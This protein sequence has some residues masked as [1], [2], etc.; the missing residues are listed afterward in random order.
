MFYVELLQRRSSLFAGQRW[1]DFENQRCSTALMWLADVQ[2]ISY[3]NLA[4]GSF[5]S[6][7]IV[8]IW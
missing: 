8:H 4:Y 5:H 2:S 1:T 7:S 6:T 3:A